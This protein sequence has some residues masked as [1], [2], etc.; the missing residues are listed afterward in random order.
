MYCDY[1]KEL[2]PLNPCGLKQDSDKR[3]YLTSTT[4]LVEVENPL[5]VTVVGRYNPHRTDSFKTRI[6]QDQ[7]VVLFNAG[8]DGRPDWQE[9]FRGTSMEAYWFLQHQTTRIRFVP[10][11]VFAFNPFIPIKKRK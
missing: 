6:N 7:T 8:G 10:I 4:E 5:Q 9:A 1:Y 2:P 11:E 3:Y